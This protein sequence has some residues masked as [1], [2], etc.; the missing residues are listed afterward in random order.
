M[1]K[2]F[3]ILLT[4]LLAFSAFSLISFADPVEEVTQQQDA[5]P[6]AATGGDTVLYLTIVIVSLIAVV[7]IGIIQ[8][9]M[10]QEQ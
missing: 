7:T 9:K 5:N 4:V 2:L 6:V 8:K 1:K 3:C 10:K